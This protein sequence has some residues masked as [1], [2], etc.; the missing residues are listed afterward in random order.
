MT[1]AKQIFSSIHKYNS[2]AFLIFIILLAFAFNAG[3]ITAQDKK[4]LKLKEAI[5][6]IKENSGEENGQKL[7]KEIC[8]RGVDFA[9]TAENEKTLRS[10]FC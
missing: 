9:L 3:T 10:R 5:S 4:P 6:K 7:V 2:T 1:F 8:E